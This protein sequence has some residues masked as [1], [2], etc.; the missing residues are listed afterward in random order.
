MYLEGHRLHSDRP[1]RNKAYSKR[2]LRS[3]KGNTSVCLFTTGMTHT[4]RDLYLFLPYKRPLPTQN[5]QVC[6]CKLLLHCDPS[7][8]QI[9]SYFM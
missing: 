1:L 7:Q 4:L 5:H 9:R 2:R 6:G 3:T 8:Y